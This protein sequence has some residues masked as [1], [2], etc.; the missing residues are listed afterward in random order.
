MR[1]RGETIERSFAHL[2][3]TGWMRRTHLRSHTNILKRLLIHAG[4]FNLG[5]IRRQLIGAGTP[6]AL[7][8]RAAAILGVFLP[9]LV[10]YPRRWNIVRPLD[11]PDSTLGH[12]LLPTCSP[13]H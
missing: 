8:G 10:M 5:L 3:E 1:R 6:R 12:I 2:Y 11:E 13:H 4:A 7:Q 9:L